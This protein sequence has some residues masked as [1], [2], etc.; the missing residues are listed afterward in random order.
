MR[1]AA[2]GAIRNGRGDWPSRFVTKSCHVSPSMDLEYVMVT[3]SGATYP[4]S[5]VPEVS[6]TI[7]SMGWLAVSWAAATLESHNSANSNRNTR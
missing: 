4:H 6:R 7:H 5:S 3:P 1:L 2:G